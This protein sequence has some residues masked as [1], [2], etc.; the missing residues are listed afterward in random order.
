M[1]HPPGMRAAK[2]FQRNLLEW[3]RAHNRELPWRANR[4]PYRVWIAEIMLQQTRIAAV[5]PYYERFLAKFPTV[6]ALARAD[7]DDV[8]KLWSGLGY[9][10][11]ARNL[12]RAAQEIVARHDREFPREFE[13]ALAL[14]GIG[15][16]TAAAVLSIAFDAP[17]AV[18]DGN[19]AR[20]LA[21][22]GAV[23]GDLR[24]P[25][26]WRGLS[27]TAQAQL[28]PKLPAHAVPGD[29]NQALMELGETV[30]TPQI[31][32]CP[33]CPVARWCLARARGLTREIP[34]PRKKRGPVRVR[35][36]AMILRDP[37]GRTLLVQ[38]PGAHD[39]VL[40]SRMWQFPAVEVT[41]HAQEEL[42]AH[43]A[44]TLE[45]DASSIELQALPAARH[46][47][48]FRNV[49]LLPFLV[50]VARL[51][52]RPRTRVLPLDRLGQLP[53]SSATHKIAAALGWSDSAK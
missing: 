10:S 9:Y 39:D 45:I 16:Y 33:A 12:H 48:T 19:V 8:L 6:E 7:Q 21:R 25:R 13:A 1:K 28:A 40:F 24:E 23:R 37:Q 53:V 46:G 51:P 50:R 41:R 27:A 11:R 14:P 35:I 5:T 44:K 26:R 32:R 15:G 49:T 42:A 52:K 34:E 18:L 30:C 22:L 47:V 29:W 2:S 38:D 31:P 20:V 36:A 4:D 17:L 43:V 3:F